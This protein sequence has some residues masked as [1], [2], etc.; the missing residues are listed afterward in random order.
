VVA[1]RLLYSIASDNLLPPLRSIAVL[2]GK[3]QVALI[4]TMIPACLALGILG[5]S[6]DSIAPLLTMCFLLCYACINLSCLVQ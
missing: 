6:L 3:S 5:S 1:P 4:V 2:S